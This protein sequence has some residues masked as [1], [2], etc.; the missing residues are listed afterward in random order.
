V[1]LLNEKLIFIFSSSRYKLLSMVASTL[2]NIV[3]PGA[4][5]GTGEGVGV[6]ATF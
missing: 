5:V 1:T 3:G 4:G 2:T 6:E